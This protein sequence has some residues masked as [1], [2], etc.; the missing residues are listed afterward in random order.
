M[1]L[2]A[3]ASLVAVVA[4]VMVSAWGMRMRLPGR[5]DA[6]K[7]DLRLCATLALDTR[8]RLHLVQTAQGQLL[9]LCGG[10]QDQILAWPPR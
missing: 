2:Q 7:A 5:R 3:G 6:D 9:V 8:R 4:L 10:T 1:V